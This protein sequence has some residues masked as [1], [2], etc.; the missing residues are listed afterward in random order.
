MK[1][2]S[3]L[4][5]RH[6]RTEAYYF[7]KNTFTRLALTLLLTL[8]LGLFGQPGLEW[9]SSINVGNGTPPQEENDWLF[10]VIV[11]SS[12]NYLGVGF[13]REGADPRQASYVMVTPSGRLLRDEVIDLGQGVQ[14]GLWNVAEAGSAYYAVGRTGSYTTQKGLMLKINKTTL[15]ATVFEIHPTGYVRSRLLEIVNVQSNGQDQYLLVSGF[16]QGSFPNDDATFKWMAAVDYNGNIIAEFVF[17]NTGLRG[18]INAFQYEILSNGNARIYF[19]AKAFMG[20]QTGGS[21]SRGDSDIRIGIVEYN[22]STGSFTET[23]S[24]SFNSINQ[25]PFDLL[26]N[27]SLNSTDIF[28][29]FPPNNFADEYPYGPKYLNLPLLERSFLNCNETQPVNGGYIEDW[30]DGSDDQPRSLELTDGPDGYI[31]VSAEL[32]RL[33]MWPTTNRDLGGDTDPGLKCDSPPCFDYDADYKWSEAYLLFFR[34]TDLGLEKATHLGTMSGADF[35]ARMIK[36]SDGG[37]AIVGSISG[38]PDGLNPISQAENILVIQVDASGDIVWRKQINGPDPGACGFSL[39]ETP[40]GGL[41]VVGNTVGGGQGGE[42]ENYLIASLGSSCDYSTAN[43]VPNSGNDYIVQPGETWTTDLYVRARVV[44]PAGVTLT[45]D[46]GAQGSINIRFAD[47][48]EAFDF[49]NRYPIGIAVQ[50]GGRLKVRDATL[51]GWDCSTE[52]M[53]DGIAVSGDASLSQTPA[54]QGYCDLLLGAVVEN[55]RLAVTACPQWI[56]QLPIVD[57]YAGTGTQSNV[58]TSFL[59]YGGTGGPRIRGI[60]ATFRNNV[61]DVIFM[62]Y[63]HNLDA[64][65]F[66]A[67]ASSAMA[68]ML[69]PAKLPTP[70]QG[71]MT[72]PNPRGRPST[73]PFGTPGSSSRVVPSQAAPS[74]T[75]GYGPSA[76]SATT[77]RSLFPVAI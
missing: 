44:I 17:P 76:S 34:K 37:F 40:G 64:S 28:Q 67:S 72:T 74:L 30:S 53:W 49:N 48:Q 52:K 65:R 20:E 14:S 21:F 45:I 68:P 3:S 61:R 7:P 71:F 66:W 5:L 8:P 19:V 42:D 13:A 12:G 1:K 47:S 55:A 73:F 38:C 70:S 2:H 23:A 36:T 6:T 69:T 50:K 77:E 35:Q 41:V 46:G 39:A 18:E 10:D 60:I 62:K 24:A 51:S 29:L 25:G 4:I 43:I 75:R 59:N 15:D 11:T 56:T 33:L 26:A 57:I 22:P 27:A 63:D 58:A 54:N 9:T 16:A 32:N 31:V